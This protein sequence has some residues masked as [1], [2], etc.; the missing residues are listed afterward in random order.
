MNRGGLLEEELGNNKPALTV[1][2][3]DDSSV[4]M[5]LASP[6][7]TVVRP[8]L[9]PPKELCAVTVLRRKKAD[10][11]THETSTKPRRVRGSSQQ[12]RR[13]R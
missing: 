6:V 1:D 4:E 10:T 7:C 13:R 5:T 8:Q 9:A 2:I 12:Q 3:R 11:R